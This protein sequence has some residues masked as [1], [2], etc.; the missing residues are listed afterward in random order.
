VS[1]LTNSRRYRIGVD[2]QILTH[3]RHAGIVVYARNIIPHLATAMPDADWILFLPDSSTARE[4]SGMRQNL[5]VRTPASMARTTFWKTVGVSAN[6]YKEKIDL[7]FVPVSRV[8]IITSCPVVAYVHDVGFIRHPE[9]LLKGTLSRTKF[10]HWYLARTAAGIL[11]STEF[12]RKE[13]CDHY[14]VDPEK[15]AVTYY[16]VDRTRFRPFPATHN[17]AEE[18]KA[19]Y[20]IKTP[21]VLTVC[22]VQARKNLARLIEAAE[23]WQRVDRD[24]SLVIAGPMGW[25]AEEIC[26]AAARRPG[27]V[28]LTG[29]VPDA[30]LP[31]LYRAAT[32]FTLPSIYEG[33]GI[34][35]AEAMASGTLCVLS[36]RSA[37][38]ETAGDGAVYYDPLQAQEIADTILRAVHS[39]RIRTSATAAGLR[40][41]ERYTWEKCAQASTSVFRTALAKG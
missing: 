33:F 32:C 24:L 2:L 11:T 29:A 31:A 35:V 27:A 28:V 20:G 36:N 40:V 22:V 37:L 19:K 41:A 8:P 4:F 21:F 10:A 14:G 12:V 23:I 17:E 26:R 38:P 39:E 25:T 15:I 1:L 18:I 16:G 34:P 3:G 5:I 6:A 30:D 13:F 9:Y 7:L